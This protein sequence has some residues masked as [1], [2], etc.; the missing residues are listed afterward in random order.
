VVECF[1][2]LLRTRDIADSSPPGDRIF[3]L[4]FIVVFL[5]P[6]TQI[7]SC[8]INLG[9][10]YF[11]VA[12]HC[13]SVILSTD[14]IE[15]ELL[16]S[17]KPRQHTTFH[18]LVSALLLVHSWFGEPGS[19]VSIVSNYGLDYRAIEF[20]SPA[21]AKRIFPMTSV[22]RPALGPTQPPVQWVPGVLS[23]GEKRGRSVTLTTHSRLV[24]RSWMNRGY[25]STPHKR[26]QGV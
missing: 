23:L 10:Y 15:S 24:P 25:T 21:E 4:R 20:R 7:P 22:S 9:H 3:W 2:L 17:N 16:M 19:S 13:S 1:A 5:S 6:F 12:C 11:R 14:A 8:Y 26:L 18:V